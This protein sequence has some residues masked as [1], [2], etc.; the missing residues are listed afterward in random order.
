MYFD[1]DGQAHNGALDRN[2]STV[3]QLPNMRSTVDGNRLK[4]GPS[5]RFV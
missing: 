4:S 1:I 5:D 3:P 2:L